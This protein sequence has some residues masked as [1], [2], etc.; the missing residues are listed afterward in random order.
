MQRRNRCLFEETSRLQNLA[1]S[2]KSKEKNS[3]MDSCYAMKIIAE[4]NAKIEKEQ[5]ETSVLQVESQSLK[6]D[7]S[8]SNHIMGQDEV[9]SLKWAERI[10]IL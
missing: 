2:R 9:L 4:L 6:D 5:E 1:D 10:P 8:T 3:H 7:C